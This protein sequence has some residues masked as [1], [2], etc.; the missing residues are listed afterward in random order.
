[1]L[2]GSLL[3][4]L[5]WGM[6][7]AQPAFAHPLEVD[8][9]PPN[10][11]QGSQK[12]KDKQEESD[13]G[14]PLLDEFNI[15]HNLSAGVQDASYYGA[16]TKSI[17]RLLND[18]LGLKIKKDVWHISPDKIGGDRACVDGECWCTVGKVSPGK[19]E[20]CHHLNK[21]ACSVVLALGLTVC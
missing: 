19:S 1:M 9:P 8:G 4:A 15:A 6:Q 2:P 3:L 17:T 16:D 13:D 20:G 11:E 5:T 12:V 21:K 7:E 14:L 18:V 10:A